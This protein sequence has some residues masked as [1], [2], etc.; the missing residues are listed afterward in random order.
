MPLVQS[1]C[2]DKANCKMFPMDGAS[3]CLR[4]FPPETKIHFKLGSV[5]QKRGGETGGTRPRRVC[6]ERRWKAEC[7]T[8]C[9]TSNTGSVAHTT[10][11][12]HRNNEYRE[13]FCIIWT[14]YFAL[15]RL[16]FFQLIYICCSAAPL[17]PLTSRGLC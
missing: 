14:P 12:N 5:R 6:K 1:K 3:W 11:C 8:L 17:L 13:E 10:N 15:S 7:C 9:L 4:A 2:S 16:T